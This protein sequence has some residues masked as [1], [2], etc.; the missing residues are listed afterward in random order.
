MQPKA[1]KINSEIFQGDSLSPV[2]SFMALLPL[3]HEL[4]ISECGYQACGT[5]MNISHFLCMDNLKLVGRS[6]EEF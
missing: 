1:I 2:L 3:T 4:N 5:V 6:E